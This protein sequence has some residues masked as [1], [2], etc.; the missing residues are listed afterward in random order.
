M[1]SE[2][3]KQKHTSRNLSEIPKASEQTSGSHSPQ[4][5]APT[6]DIARKSS[7]TLPMP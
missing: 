5:T 7:G 1:G 3:G 6:G 4:L 2:K